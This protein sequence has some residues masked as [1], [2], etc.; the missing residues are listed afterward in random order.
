MTL[1]EAIGQYVIE[2]AWNGDDRFV[3]ESRKAF[4]RLLNLIVVAFHIQRTYLQSESPSHKALQLLMAPF[5]VFDILSYL[6]AL[7]KSCNGA[8][9]QSYSVADHMF[10]SLGNAILSGLRLLALLKAKSR[11]TWDV[12]WEARAETV[13]CSFNDW[14]LQEDSLHRFLNQELCLRLIKFLSTSTED[15]ALGNLNRGC[16]YHEHSSL[17]GFVDLPEYFDG[18]VNNEP[19]TFFDTTC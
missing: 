16:Q 11:S 9:N 4:D 2:V 1:R 13:R 18:L 8:V 17:R 3:P 10:R 15:Q 12:D 7:R 19:E 6:L 5:E 14:P